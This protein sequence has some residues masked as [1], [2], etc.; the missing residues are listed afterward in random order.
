MLLYSST[1]RGSTRAPRGVV[2]RHSNLEH[3]MSAIANYFGLTADSR[4]FSWLPPYHDM[5]LIGGVLTP[6][7]VGFPIGLMSPLDFLRS[8]LSWLQR[9]S[10]DRVTVSGGPNFAYDLCVSRYNAEDRLTDLDLSSWSVAFNGRR[11]C[12]LANPGGIR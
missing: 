9:I 8:P 10:E 3:N 7:Y 5:G 11:Y 4:G 2:V 6:L 12:P 1:R